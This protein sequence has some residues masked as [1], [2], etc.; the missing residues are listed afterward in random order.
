MSRDLSN[1]VAH[2]S[3]S[4]R[5][6]CI[7][8][9]DTLFDQEIGI[10]ECCKHEFCFTCLVEWS[11]VRKMILIVECVEVYLFSKKIHVQMIVEYFNLF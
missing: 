7:I 6:Q 11:K 2:S 5:E 4:S 1:Q 9:Y 3:K 10:P 8:C